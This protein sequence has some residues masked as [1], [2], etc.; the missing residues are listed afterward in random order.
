MSADD[1]YDGDDGMEKR[2]EV[3]GV[4]V[5]MCLIADLHRMENLDGG[6]WEWI[7]G[8]VF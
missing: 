2:G 4:R 6:H 1:G 5:W 3:S 8:G 7:I